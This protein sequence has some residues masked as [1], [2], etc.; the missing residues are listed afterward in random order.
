MLFQR[1]K[2]SFYAIFLLMLFTVS[3]A[4]TSGSVTL[5][6]KRVDNTTIAAMTKIL[7]SADIVRSSITHFI[8]Q[9]HINGTISTE[10]AQKYMTDIYPSTEVALMQARQILIAFAQGTSTV[11]EVESSLSVLNTV[12]GH[13]QDFATQIGWKKPAEVLP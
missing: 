12:V 2:Q 5:E 6:G 3:L 13:A 4:C 1:S 11:T 7:V 9:G 10:T 8:T